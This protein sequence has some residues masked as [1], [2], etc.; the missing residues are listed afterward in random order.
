MKKFRAI[1]T[2]LAGEKKP[3]TPKKYDYR[4]KERKDYTGQQRENLP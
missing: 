1:I 2:K 4:T 3:I